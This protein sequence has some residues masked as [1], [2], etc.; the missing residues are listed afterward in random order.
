[1]IEHLV[2]ERAEGCTCRSIMVLWDAVRIGNYSV[3]EPDGQLDFQECPHG[4]TVRP[5]TAKDCA[6]ELGLDEALF[7]PSIPTPSTPAPPG[8]HGV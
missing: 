6:E 4:S 3:P 7:W 2:I 5:A 1:M 8:W